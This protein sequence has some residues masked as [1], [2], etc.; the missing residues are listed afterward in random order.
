MCSSK[1]MILLC[2]YYMAMHETNFLQFYFANVNRVQLNVKTVLFKKN[3]FSIST[4]FSSI[5]QK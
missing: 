4:Q 3:Q 1:G 2:Y 5:G